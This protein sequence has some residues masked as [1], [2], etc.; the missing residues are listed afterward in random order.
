MEQR[1]KL[2]EIRSESQRRERKKSNNFKFQFFLVN[3]PTL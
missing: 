3:E 1:N 2:F